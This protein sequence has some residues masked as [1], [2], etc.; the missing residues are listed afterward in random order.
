MIKIDLSNSKNTGVALRS[1]I[2]SELKKLEKSDK[3]RKK[4]LKKAQKDSGQNAQVSFDGTE[5]VLIMVKKNKYDSLPE[6]YKE[7]LSSFGSD[8]KMHGR[9]VKVK[10]S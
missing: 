5:R 1:E 6:A 2:E 10:T 9:F 4:A 8:L 7:I 3:D